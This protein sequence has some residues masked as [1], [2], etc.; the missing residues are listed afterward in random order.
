MNI[1]K[2][3][4]LAILASVLFSGCSDKYMLDSLYGI[5][6]QMDNDNSGFFLNGKKIRQTKIVSINGLSPVRNAS[7]IVYY[8]NSGV[9]NSII[10]DN[11]IPMTKDVVMYDNNYT[12]ESLNSIKNQ[13]LLVD[14]LALLLMQEK[15]KNISNKYSN[16]ATQ[17]SEIK[18]LKKEI[19]NLKVQDS[20]T[21]TSSTTDVDIKNL[22]D[23]IKSIES[24]VANID[25]N[26]TKINNVLSKLKTPDNN[27]TKENCDTDSIPQNI[28]LEEKFEYQYRKFLKCLGAKK[29]III[30]RWNTNNSNETNMNGAEVLQSDKEKS[31]KNSGFA[32]ASDIKI[33]RLKINNDISSK[34]SN[35][36]TDNSI[37]HKVGIVTYMLKAKNLITINR[38]DYA[39]AMRLALGLENLG[40]IS[41]QSTL[42][43]LKQIDKLSINISKV[44]LSNISSTAQLSAPNEY[45][46]H[47]KNKKCTSSDGKEIKI[48]E[49]Y[50]PISYVLSEIDNFGVLF[51]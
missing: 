38:E 46:C 12:I 49:K 13:L 29:N 21:S 16:L 31:L 41:L 43:A 34:L 6:T 4:L 14:K 37:Y 2:N 40:K 33:E 9:E 45:S 10:L 19:E 35:T 5:N 3:I 39:N 48:Y 51:K 1:V 20:N 42:E 28:S 22:Q 8:T 30:I 25:N 36:Y 32:I 44:N 7:D 24:G 23:K 27:T 26:I 15:L 47:T 18:N 17:E 50:I 11:N